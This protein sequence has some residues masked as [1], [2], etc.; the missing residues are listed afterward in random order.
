[1]II[2]TPNKRYKIRLILQSLVIEERKQNQSVE[3]TK[4]VD[5]RN[6]YITDTPVTRSAT[7]LM[8]MKVKPKNIAQGHTNNRY[9]QTLS[10]VINESENRGKKR[11]EE[12]IFTD[13]NKIRSSI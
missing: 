9:N 4:A 2:S 5:P 11:K 1:M 12:V 13:P 8:E 3:K 6:I 7:N 10:H